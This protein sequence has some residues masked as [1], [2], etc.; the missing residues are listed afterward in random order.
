MDKN[1]VSREEFTY[2]GNI[3]RY[4]IHPCNATWVN[5]RSVELPI[6]WEL[7]V[8]ACIADKLVLEVGN[9]LQNYFNIRFLHTLVILD[10]YEKGPDVVNEDIVTY[11]PATKYDL[12]VSMSTLEHVGYGDSCFDPKE[13]GKIM[14][15]INNMKRLLSPGGGMFISIPYAYNPE[16]QEIILSGMVQFKDMVC[17]KRVNKDL[18]QWVET[19]LDDI[20][21]LPYQVERG[22]ETIVLGYVL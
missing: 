3:Y 9:V 13:P 12:I 20:M 8:K 5:E 19:D 18:N 15:A 22:V 6:V 21:D 7:V 4:F 17:Y 14:K 11:D 2:R 1:K 16:L 10:K